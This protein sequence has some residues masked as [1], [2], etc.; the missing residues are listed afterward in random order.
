MSAV[1]IRFATADDAG[2]LLQLVRD[3]AAYERAPD[4]VVA[5]EEDLRRHSFGPE[6]QFEA[7]LAF[8]DGKPRPWHS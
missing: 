2:L 6:R 3:L 5:A 1:R 7:L 8:V 4:A